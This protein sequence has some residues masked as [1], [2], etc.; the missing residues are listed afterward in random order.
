MVTRAMSQLLHDRGAATAIS[1]VAVY[2]PNDDGETPCLVIL[3][4]SGGSRHQQRTEAILD[5]IDQVYIDLWKR[6]HPLRWCFATTF[7][8]AKPP[9]KLTATFLGRNPQLHATVAA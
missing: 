4:P 7:E 8:N 1:R 3:P 2:R 5:T 6:F 9:K